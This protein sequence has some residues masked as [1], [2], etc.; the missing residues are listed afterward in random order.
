MWGQDK[1]PQ[2]GDKS[3]AALVYRTSVKHFKVKNT[4]LKDT[5]GKGKFKR[6]LSFLLVDKRSGF[7]LQNFHSRNSKFTKFSSQPI[8]ALGLLWN[9]TKQ[10]SFWRIFRYILYSIF[11]NITFL[12]RILCICKY[13]IFD[14]RIIHFEIGLS[15]LVWDLCWII[16]AMCWADFNSL[17]GSTSQVCITLTCIPSVSVWFWSNERPR[18]GILGFGR[19]RNETKSQ[20][21]KEGGGG[22][23]LPSFIPHPLPALLL[24]PFF[25][26]SWTLVPRSL[27]PSRTETLTTQAWARALLKPY[28]KRACNRRCSYGQ[29]TV[30]DDRSGEFSLSGLSRG[31]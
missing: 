26:R 7:S 17:N 21:M 28:N 23:R 15:A 27:L 16:F 8:G 24:A 10:R 12:N 5:D 4:P 20:K 2:K 19:A 31:S 3:C 11:K 29:K 25:A 13:F 22:E 1:N 6:M 30:W 14:G 9:A 18:N